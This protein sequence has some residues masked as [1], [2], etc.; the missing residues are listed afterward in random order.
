M[1]L[2][3]ITLTNSG[4]INYTLNCLKSLENIGAQILPVSYCVGAEGHN[5]LLANR[6]RSV[7]IKDDDTKNA[8]FQTFRKGNWSNITFKK[9]ELIYENLIMNDFVLF[10]DGDIVYENPE[11]LQYLVDNIKDRE[12]LTQNDCMTD[13]DTSQLCSG[14]MFIHS[15]ANT[16]ILFNPANAQQ[17]KNI[18]GWDDQ[19]Y[20]NQIKHRLNFGLLPLDLFPTGQYYYANSTR[21][22]PYIIHFNWL[23]GHEKEKKMI[24]YGKWYMPINSSN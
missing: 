3:F 9:L 23:V 21:L 10:T 22:T 16:R 14:F 11:F 7:F 13:N 2:S 20:V 19:V 6:Y 1:R 24:E 18:V 17:Y 5:R 8:E 4:Y 15:T 12:I